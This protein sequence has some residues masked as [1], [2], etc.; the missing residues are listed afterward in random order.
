MM[1]KKHTLCALTLLCSAPALANIPIESRGLSQNSGSTSTPTAIG[2]SNSGAPV[3]TNLNWQLMQKNQQLE[4]DIRTLRGKME[5]QEN[6]I[7][8][9]KHELTNRYTDLDQRLELLNQKIDPEAAPAVEEDNQQDS[10]PS[11][12]SSS[13][14][15]SN[16]VNNTA[17]PAPAATTVVST[18]SST[19]ELE[20]AAY[21][22]A[23]DAYKQGGAKKAIAPMQNFIKNHPNSVYI[24]NAYFWLAE[25]NLAIEPT[26][27]NEAKKNFEI[28]ASKYPNSSKASNAVYRLYSIAKNVDKNDALAAQYRSTLLTKYPSSQEASFVKSS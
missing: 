3:T 22:I 28:V 27:Y 9:L 4:N 19:E 12:A 7:A 15:A 14:P 21:T 16:P 13:Q 1:L 25:F 17:A 2:A 18:Q 26:N 10:S 24:S 5:E 8:Q 11:T 6:E 20:K 23:L